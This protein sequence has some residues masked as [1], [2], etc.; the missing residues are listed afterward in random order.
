MVNQVT[1]PFAREA[2]SKELVVV[3]ADIDEAFL[4]HTWTNRPAHADEILTAERIALILCSSMTRA[5]LELAQQELGICEPFICESGAAI[6]IPDRYFPF[7]VL[8]DRDLPGYHVIEFG[9]PYPEI[10]ARLH[11]TAERLNTPVVGFSDETVDQVAQERGLSLSH[12]RL[13]KLREYDEPFRLLRPSEAARTRLWRALRASGLACFS[14]GSMEHVGAPV[15]RAAA[16]TLLSNLY[17]RTFDS[18]V[19]ASFGANVD[20]RAL[21]V[22]FPFLTMAPTQSNGHGSSHSAGIQHGMDRALWIE[23]IVEIADAAR[24]GHLNARTGH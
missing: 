7:D 13:A 4:K 19:T 12:A 24:E 21:P 22:H 20:G 1:S 17:R 5:Q 2:R 16:V 15:N 3:F 9:R 10:V 23:T 8:R 11:R 14:S 18:V 6:L